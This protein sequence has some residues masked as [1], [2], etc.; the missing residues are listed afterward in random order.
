MSD[1]SSSRP[2]EKKELPVEIRLLI[3]FIL[4]GAV[5]FTTPYFFKTPPGPQKTDQAP[6]PKTETPPPPA[7][8][9]PVATIAPPAGQI[10]AANEETLT[11]DTDVYHIVFSNK[12][13]VVRSWIFKSTWTRTRSRWRW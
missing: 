9:P 3:A 4:M 8:A 2:P 1:S 10:A 5:L 11:V 6:A 7:E 13:A 12:G